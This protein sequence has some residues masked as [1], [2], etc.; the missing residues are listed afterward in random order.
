[1]RKSEA[2]TPLEFEKMD[3]CGHALH[4]KGQESVAAVQKAQ[5]IQR[6]AF[7]IRLGKD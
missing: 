3:A 4:C 5:A 7:A 6:S 2:L 1:M